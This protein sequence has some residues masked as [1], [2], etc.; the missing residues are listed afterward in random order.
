MKFA[1]IMKKD[2]DKFLI[3]LD[4]ITA[5][6]GTPPENIYN[7]RIEVKPDTTKPIRAGFQNMRDAFQFIKDKTGL[8]VEDKDML[9]RYKVINHLVQATSL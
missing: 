4:Q 2:T 8:D 5:W 3:L 1:Y 9:P 7:V 6:H